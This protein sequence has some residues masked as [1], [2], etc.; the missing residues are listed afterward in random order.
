MWYKKDN[1]LYTVSMDN[2]TPSIITTYYD[3][4]TR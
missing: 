1:K 2:N 3:G 4:D